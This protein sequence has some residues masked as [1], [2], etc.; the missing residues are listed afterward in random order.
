MPTELSTSSHYIG[1]VRSFRWTEALS[2]MRLLQGFLPKREHFRIVAERSGSE[3]P[4]TYFAAL[5]PTST[6][7]KV[8]GFGF[9]RLEGD[10][11]LSSSNS[12]VGR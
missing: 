2:M 12:A 1:R 8:S 9:G 6:I 7:M 4:S 11:A 5:R 10:P 3:A